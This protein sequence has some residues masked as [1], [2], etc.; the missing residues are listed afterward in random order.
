MLDPEQNNSFKDHYIDI[1]FDL[2][3]VLFVTTANDISSIP[4]PLRDR[5]EII[6]LYS[7]T[8]NEKFNIIKKHLIPKQ[9]KRYNIKPSQL[10]IRDDAISLIISGYT[11][12]A[13]VRSAER[14]VSKIIRKQAV[15]ICEGH[16]GK[17][18]VKASD[19]EE[20]L[21]PRKFRDDELVRQDRVGVVNGLA[22]TSV[23]GE[24]LEIEAVAVQG[25]GK[26][27]LTGSLG[28]V[29]KESAKAAYS[30]IR[31]VADKY[32]IDTEFYKNTDIHLHFP[33]GAVPKDGPSAGIGITAAMV[34]ALAG[35][36]VKSD[37]AMTGE[38]T[39]TGRVLPIG[40]LKEKSMAAYK[41]NIKKVIIPKQNSSDIKEFD[42]EVKGSVE[43][44]EVNDVGEVLSLALNLADKPKSKK[45]VVT[46]SKPEKHGA[47]QQ[48]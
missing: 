15:R 41:N 27:E 7:Y 43:F 24:M 3:R 32:G 10:K 14:V 17:I 46:E 38:V 1:P 20:I 40:G 29:M 30:Y 2:S 37:V 22:W 31:S 33:E 28:D 42:D 9:L 11:K 18:T 35:C 23:G 8:F 44:V 19:L 39:L 6:E 34:S 26:L 47:W 48:S 16:E 4:A 13:G 21:G 25:T 12:E 36:T 5:M 45:V